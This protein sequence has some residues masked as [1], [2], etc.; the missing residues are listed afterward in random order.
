M[1][2][3]LGIATPDCGSR[4]PPDD[5]HASGQL[6]RHPSIRATDP[7]SPDDGR[8]G[9]YSL[10]SE[11]HSTPVTRA[12]VDETLFARCRRIVEADMASVG[13]K[14][15]RRRPTRANGGDEVGNCGLV[16][17]PVHGAPSSIRSNE[18]E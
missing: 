4:G 6:E 14:T 9:P 5:M 18:I 3:K 8:R 10:Q 7:D 2:F 1:Q 17:H 15:E 16:V 13:T 11:P 12:A